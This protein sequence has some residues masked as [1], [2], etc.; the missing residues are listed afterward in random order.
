MGKML[1]FTPHPLLLQV[2]ETVPLPQNFQLCHIFTIYV[3]IR[4]ELIYI[5]V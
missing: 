1:N 4:C 3:H 2:L 5:H